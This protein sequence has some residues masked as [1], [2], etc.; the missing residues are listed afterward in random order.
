MDQ[1]IV[2]EMERL[3]CEQIREQKIRQKIKE[4]SSELRDLEQKLNCAYMNKERSLQLEEK[5]LIATRNKFE[6]I[7]LYGN[8]KD[9]AKQLENDQ[10]KIQREEAEKALEYK[11]SLHR[12]VAENEQKRQEEF[13]QFLKEKAMVDEIIQNIAEQNEQEANSRLQK[14]NETRQ[15]IQQFMSEREDWLKKEKL[16]QEEENKKIAQYGQ[17]QLQREKDLQN[18]KKLVA[19]DKDA[20]YDKLASDMATQE[21]VKLELE[22]LRIDLAHEEQEALKREEEKQQIQSRIRKRLELIDAYQN[23]IT[24]KIMREKEQKISEAQYRANL[25]AKFAEDDRVEQMKE[26]ARRMK[27]NAHRKAAEEFIIERRKRLEQ[28]AIEEKELEDYEKKL[29]DYRRMVI[30]QERQR[31]L[32]NHA[33]KL[34]GFLPK[35]LLRDQN[36]LDLFDENFRAKFGF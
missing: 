22:E 34:V 14:R 29:D 24:L 20:I 19:A 3:Q 30:E 13:E 4:G 32:V 9:K 18:K 33:T 1:R 36:D 16:R 31:L 11:K 12:Q 21:K 26:V 23:Q 6:E 17:M 7:A 27:Q 15:F 5:R 28:E 25:L 10:A 2:E 35:G 8:W